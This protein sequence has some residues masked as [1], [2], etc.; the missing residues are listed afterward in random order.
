[1][2]MIVVSR[3]AFG[4]TFVNQTPVIEKITAVG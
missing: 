3:R 2:Q 1:M 4:Q